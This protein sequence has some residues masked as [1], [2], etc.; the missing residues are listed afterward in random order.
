MFQ[1]FD[2]RGGP[3]A[4]ARRVARLREMLAARGL[5][6]WLVPHADPYQNE[7]QPACEERLLWLTGFSGSWGL[8]VVL[9]GRA[10]LFVDG[11]YTLQAEQQTDRSVFEIIKAPD[12]KPDD[13]LAETLKPGQRLGFDPRLQTIAG[14]RK[15][16]EAA[17]TAGAVLL[18]ISDNPVEA[19]WTDRPAPP[20]N[21]VALHPLT[22]AGETASDKITRVREALKRDGDD[23]ALLSAPES[24]AW[25]LN[26]RGSDVAHTPIALCRALLPAH[27]PLRLFIEPERLGEEVRAA[28]ADIA[29]VHAPEALADELADFAKDGAPRIRLNPNHTSRWL[30]CMVE[31]SGAEIVEAADPCV[32]FKAIKNDTEIA[33]ARASHLRDGVA[34]TRFLAWLDANAPANRIDEIKAAQRLE[35]F[36]AETGELQDIS[37]DTISGAGPN[38]AIVHYRVT[39]AT[40]RPLEPGTLYLVD[41]GGQYRDGTTD[42][43]R[44]VAIGQPSAAMRRHFTLVLKGHIA[45]AT[46]RFPMGARGVDIDGF[47]RRALWA[48][49]LDYDHGTGHGVG[50]FLGVH[51]GPASISKR[52]MVELEPGMI[53]SNEPGYY[54]EGEY[55][56]RIENLLLVLPPEPIAGGE[57]EMMRFETLTL[58]PIDR[59][60]V[61]PELLRQDERTWLD[62]YHAHVRARLA[63]HL[64]G[65][66]LAWL[67]K[68]TLPLAG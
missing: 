30:A 61:V 12:T 32:R 65:D 20:A 52:G 2:D 22:F 3:A 47:A 17:E 63:P 9:P 26:I 38:G 43:T 57:R 40:N 53:L 29:T 27:G 28:L 50:S 41:S 35:A 36:R 15:L 44:T 5:D 33:G 18:P 4:V 42:I 68:A 31:D 16:R 64:D 21:P 8:A 11:R 37:F 66:E 54:R 62:A 13:W 45:V 39:R 6:G 14:A 34:V 51:E 24:V 48:A 19:L 1:N 55:G 23:A 25:L 59:R 10:V 60:L 49:G 46:A 58:A 56:I 67:E 7:F